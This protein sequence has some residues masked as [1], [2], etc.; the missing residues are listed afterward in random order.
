V[1]GL[2]VGQNGVTQKIVQ[3]KV[4]KMKEFSLLLPSLI[5]R[6]GNFKQTKREIYERKRILGFFVR[7]AKTRE[8]QNG[9]GKYQI[10]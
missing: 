2:P 5:V 7:F 8:S 3:L 9:H 4:K 1:S 6:A 10:R